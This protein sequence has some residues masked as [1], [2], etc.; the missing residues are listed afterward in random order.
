MCPGVTAFHWRA[1]HSL[2]PR[3]STEIPQR[4]SSTRY[5]N[6]LP[7]QYWWCRGLLQQTLQRWSLRQHS[8]HGPWPCESNRWQHAQVKVRPHHADTTDSPGAA[9]KANSLH[10]MLCVATAARPV[11]TWQTQ[12][13]VDGHTCCALHCISDGAWCVHICDMQPF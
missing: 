10:L 4:D 3:T 6:S 1:A 9:V 7:T 11:I 2:P 5:Q 13:A 12:L 8:A